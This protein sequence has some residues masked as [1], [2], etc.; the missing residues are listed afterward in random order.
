MTHHGSIFQRHS[1]FGRSPQCAAPPVQ[2]EKLPFLR[3]LRRKS[4]ARRHLSQVVTAAGEITAE[5]WAFSW[6]IKGTQSWGNTSIFTQT[7]RSYGAERNICTDSEDEINWEK[8]TIQIHMLM[9]ITRQEDIFY[10]NQRKDFT[11]SKCGKWELL[12][13]SLDLLF[14]KKH[15]RRHETLCKLETKA[16]YGKLYWYFTYS[17]FRYETDCFSSTVFIHII[18]LLN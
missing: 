13:L 1:N 4:P 17:G 5:T 7:Q 6:R 3:A 11:I 14:K 18:T 15:W 16:L 8:V 2:G 10:V 9:C 12:I